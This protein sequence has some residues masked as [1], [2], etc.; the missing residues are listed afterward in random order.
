MDTRDGVHGTRS[1]LASHGVA[2]AVLSGAGMGHDRVRDGTGWVHTALSHG[3]HAH[4]A[5]SRER[6]AQDTCIKLWSI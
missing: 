2:P 3:H 1:G 6:G 5:P 4:R